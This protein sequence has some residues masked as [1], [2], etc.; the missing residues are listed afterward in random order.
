MNTLLTGRNRPLRTLVLVSATGGNLATLIELSMDR[1]DLFQVAL[2]ASDR[3]RCGALDLAAE[4]S[5]E[6]WPG[7]FERACGRFSNLRTADDRAEYAWNA[8]R[9]H[10]RLADRIERYEERSGGID[11]VVLAYHRWI[12][13]R[14]LERF[15]GRMINQHPGDLSVLG[16]DGERLLIGLDPVG[17][18][19][20]LGH[21][22]TRTSTFLVDR[23]HDGGAIL[24]R[25]PTVPFRFAEPTTETLTRHEEQQ[26]MVS[27]RPTLRWVLEAI[28]S[29]RIGLDPV[30]L[31]PDRS[32]V[33]SID[34]RPTSLGG[35][36]IK[37]A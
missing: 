37:R 21:A 33:V 13:G 24:A 17:E 11:L 18:A 23:H 22:S 6:S 3:P 30:A 1:P 16:A 26:K 9:F 32:P 29:G 2:V 19:H 10:D 5:V 7:D 12:H 31:H 14:L 8:Q 27:D 20:R 34:G 15:A 35:Y 25:G 4:H 36:D 28:A